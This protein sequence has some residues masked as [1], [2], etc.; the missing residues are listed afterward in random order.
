M[1]T[2]KQCSCV[3]FVVRIS[4]VFTNFLLAGK[5]LFVHK[6]VLSL[7]LPS[8]TIVASSVLCLNCSVALW[9]DNVDPDQTA[10]VGAIWS[11][12]TMFTSFCLTTLVNNVTKSC[13]GRL[14]RG[15][16]RCIFFLLIYL[17]YLAG[18]LCTLVNL[19]FFFFLC[20]LLCR[21]LH[22]QAKHHQGILS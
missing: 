15:H 8:K 10:P 22:F 11:G 12:S 5:P 18:A 17:F 2:D 14:G 19:S 20:C 21:L 16:F 3:Q 9:L 7:I 6:Q 1:P 13:R 4:V